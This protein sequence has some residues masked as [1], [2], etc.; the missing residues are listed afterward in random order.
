M[1]VDA[2]DF[3]EIQRTF[4]NGLQKWLNGFNSYKYDAT[5]DVSQFYK[6]VV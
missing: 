3:C 6:S 1:T 5:E 2:K 4:D